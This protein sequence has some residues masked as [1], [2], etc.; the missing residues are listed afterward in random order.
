MAEGADRTVG[1]ANGPG[2]VVGKNKILL[3]PVPVA[4]TT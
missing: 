1:V 4:M 2:S 3:L